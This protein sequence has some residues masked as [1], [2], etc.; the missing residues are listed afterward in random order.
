MGLANRGDGYVLARPDIEFYSINFDVSWRAGLEPSFWYGKET[1]KEEMA[2]AD[3]EL[4]AV[5]KQVAAGKW[6]QRRWAANRRRVTVRR[7]RFEALEPRHLLAVI[8]IEPATAPNVFDNDFTRIDNAIWSATNGDT[9]ELDGTFDW[10]EA[11]AAAS[12]AANGRA[13]FVPNGL[14]NVTL[15]AANGLGTATIQGPGDNPALDIEYESFLYF[16]GNNPGW[17]ISELEILDFDVA[18]LMVG[19]ASNTRIVDNY[20]RVPAD[21][22]ETLMTPAEEFE[23]IAINLSRGVNQ[24][25]SGNLIE[26]PGTGL[27]DTASDIYALSVGI[28]SIATGGATYEGLEISNNTFRVLGAQSADPERI[29]GLWENGHAHNSDIN[30]FGNTFENADAGNDAAVNRQVAFRI[31]SHSSATT[32]VTYDDNTVDGAS[33]AFAWLCCIGEPDADFSAYAPVVLTQ[34]VVTDVGI[35]LL[36]QAQGSA[37]LSDNTLTGV[38]TPDSIGVKIAVGSSASIVGRIGRN[39]IS[40]FEIGVDVNGSL[41]LVEDANLNGNTIGVLIR[42]GGM[43]DLGDLCDANVTGL[44]TGSGA[45]NGSSTGGN[46]FSS[47]TTTATTTNGAIVVLNVDNVPGPQGLGNGDIPA[48]GNL[49]ANPGFAG[50]ENVAYHDTDDPNAAFV[51]FAEEPMIISRFSI[52]NVSRLEGNSGTTELMFTVSLS[53]PCALPVM[54]RVDTA[55][56]TATA[57]DNDYLPI[58]NLVLAFDPGKPLEQTVTVNVV[59]DTKAEL[60]ETFFVRLSNPLLNGQEDERL[61]VG[62][63]QASGTIINDDPWLTSLVAAPN[64][65]ALPA[66]IT[67]TAETGLGA[68]EIVVRV[69][70]YRDVNGNGVW[71]ESDEGVGFDDDGSD[72]W[73]WSGSMAGWDL[74]ERS[75]F[76]RAEGSDGKFSESSSV[77]VVVAREHPPIDLGALPL[78]TS[79]LRNVALHNDGSAVLTVRGAGLNLPFEISPAG[80]LGGDEDWMISPGTSKTFVVTAIAAEV[81]NHDGGLVMIGAAD[82]R[83]VQLS[84]T[85]ISGWHNERYAE[86]VDGD[87]RV[88]PIDALIVINEINRNNAGELPPRTA[89]NPGP[90]Y[91]FDTTNNGDVAPLDVLHVINYINWRAGAPAEGEAGS[92]AAGANAVVPLPVPLLHA[93]LTPRSAIASATTA[94]TGTVAVPEPG[95]LYPASAPATSA[96]PELAPLRARDVDRWLADQPLLDIGAA[97]DPFKLDQVLADCLV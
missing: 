90:P 2:M 74:G 6:R 43:A 23:N 60:D 39:S 88:K 8:S 3:N 27:S 68:D 83:L 73:S 54:V 81:G 52:D 95:T 69:L 14:S 79:T 5:G 24:V 30:I 22:L 72:A 92:L 55:D 15:T 9:I 63:G 89:E 47:Y 78:F 48:Q 75:L 82:A 1:A 65:A 61:S 31:T 93:F 10:T 37:W 41:A 84:V 76:A 62:T 21:A 71:D 67:L 51:L 66:E 40:G 96:S 17:E 36:I 53:A 50:I 49:W 45:T 28:R 20:I 26:F 32:T 44:E 85:V 58:E 34:N 87:G 97:V 46:D 56:G 4:H 25:V 11:N 16:E 77:T 59:G 38:A 64:P 86:D 80:G 18:V 91:F 12:W 33:V 13:I 19:A 94:P 29:F 7:G 42:S 70:F 35:G 57:Q